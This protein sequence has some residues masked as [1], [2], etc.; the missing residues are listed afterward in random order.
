MIPAT[1][2]AP[3]IQISVSHDKRHFIRRNLPAASQPFP[4]SVSGALQVYSSLF[5]LLIQILA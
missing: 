1:M 2:A 3:A 5:P 4:A